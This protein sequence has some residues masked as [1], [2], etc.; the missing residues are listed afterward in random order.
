MKKA[1]QWVLLAAAI[2]A[3]GSGGLAAA[4]IDYKHPVAVIPYAATKPVI[5]G[6]VDDAEWQGAFSQRALQTTG[7][8]ISAPPGAVLDDVGRGEPLRRHARAR[9]ARA[10]GPS[11]S[12]ETA[13]P[14][15]SR[16]IFDDCYEIWVSV[17]ATDPL[18]GQPHCFGPVPR[19]LR[20]GALRRHPPARRSATRAPAATTPTGN[21]R[22]AS[23]RGT[24]GRWSWSSRGP[25]WAPPTAR[26]TTALHFRTL[27]ARNYKRPWEQN[28]F[29][30]TV[31][32]LGDRYPSRVRHVQ[33]RAGPAPAGVGDADQRQDRAAAG[34][35]RARP[36]CQIAWRYVL[37][38]R[39]QGRHGR[40]QEGQ[41]GRGRQPAGTRHGR[42]T[43]TGKVRITVTD[44]GR[45]A[46]A[47]LPQLTQRRLRD[48]D[49]QGGDQADRGDVLNLG[50]TFNPDRDYARV[51]GDFI[52]YDNRA[53]PSRRS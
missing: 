15:G 36:T 11:S 25:A 45:P 47:R 43:A 6:K 28:S 7:R 9:C 18:T 16:Q 3:L 19:Q 1:H 23:P 49:P 52:N 31:D 24:S 33:D 26:S 44:A 29:E 27:I 13:G 8:T 41:A 50:I 17:D 14:A 35:P 38:C 34:R 32:L 22:A 42:A 40:G 2:T 39:D 5:D 12:I 21:R 20:R 48:G 4:E 10:S 53:R 37:G 46:A 51:F 30:G